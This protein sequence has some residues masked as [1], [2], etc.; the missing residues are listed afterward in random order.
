[1]TNLLELK[2]F[3]VKGMDLFSYYLSYIF[4]KT[5]W[6]FIYFENIGSNLTFLHF[7]KNSNRDVYDLCTAQPQSYTERLY[8]ALEKFFTEYVNSKREVSFFLSFLSFVFSFNLNLNLI[9]I[10]YHTSIFYLGI[11]FWL[12]MKAPG[13][14]L[15]V[16]QFI[17][18]SFVNI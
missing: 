12:N 6:K 11:L 17:L 16:E 7:M 3:S 4:K 9:V 18:I 1:M 8:K 13:K 2:E 14:S 15:E 5:Y 10:E